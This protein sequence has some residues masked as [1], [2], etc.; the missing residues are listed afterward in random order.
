[1]KQV[2]DLQDGMDPEC[3]CIACL[4]ILGSM[5]NGLLI[6]MMAQHLVASYGGVTR[7]IIPHPALLPIWKGHH[8]SVFCHHVWTLIRVKP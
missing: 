3:D 5:E 7:C 2:L 4:R 8:A 6:Y 1:M